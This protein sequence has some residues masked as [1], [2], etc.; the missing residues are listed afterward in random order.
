MPALAA[1]PTGKRLLTPY[2]AVYELQLDKTHGIRNTKA[3]NGRIQIDFSGSSCKGYA[4][5]FH[6]TTELLSSEGKTRLNDLRGT[7]WEDGA[8]RVFRF[9]SITSYNHAQTEI[10]EGH[11]ERGAKSVTVHLRKPK[12]ES[13]SEPADVVFPAE[14]N[15][16]IIEAAR[17]GRRIIAFPFYDGSEN[18]KKLYNTLTVIGRAIPPGRRPP[19]DAAGKNPLMNRLIRWP[20]TISYYDQEKAL[21]RQSGEQTPTYITVFELYGNGIARALLLT[22]SDITIK[23]R[24]TSLKVKK[25]KPC[26]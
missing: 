22:Y 4:Q 13:F 5:Q 21:Q 18:G 24:L 1:A 26:Y 9:Y 14:Q 12:R 17:A 7:T 3:V 11:A 2:R 16:R 15:R 23:G 20:V 8:A 6:Q 19:D 10:I 25:P